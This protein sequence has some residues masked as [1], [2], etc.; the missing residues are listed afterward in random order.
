[1]TKALLLAFLVVAA[2][3][4]MSGVAELAARL[5]GLLPWWLQLV[6]A[7]LVITTLTWGIIARISPR[8]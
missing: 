5:L 8:E 4:L 7:W 1:M 2:A 3:M 6:T